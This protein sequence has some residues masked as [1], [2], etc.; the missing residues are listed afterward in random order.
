MDT[1]LKINSVINSI[2]WG[3]FMLCVLL[4]VGVFYTIKLRFFQVTHFRLW[5]DKTFLSLFRKTDKQK[6]K[7]LSPFQAM[8]TALAGAIGT[9]NIVGV[10]G[11]ITLG[12]AGAVFWMWVAA[13]FGMGTV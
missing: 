8:S 7:G 11:A 10:A 4:G 9:G 1:I 5:W 6:G 12:G 13:F 3:P 2:V